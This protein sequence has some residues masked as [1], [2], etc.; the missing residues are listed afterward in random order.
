MTIITGICLGWVV[1]WT[2][3]LISWS[4][5]NFENLIDKIVDLH[6]ALFKP[7]ACCEIK[8]SKLAPLPEIKPCVCVMVASA[9]LFLH[10]PNSAWAEGN[11]ASFSCQLPTQFLDSADLLTLNS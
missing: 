1:A 5:G 10:V 8:L 9:W 4:G 6:A 3:G 2:V 7:F 11:L